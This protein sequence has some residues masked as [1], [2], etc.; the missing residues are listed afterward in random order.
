MIFLLLLFVILIV[1]LV[2]RRKRKV[3]RQSPDTTSDDERDFRQVIRPVWRTGASGRY[4]GNWSK[5]IH[6]NRHVPDIDTDGS[7][8]SDSGNTINGT[9]STKTMS[10]I[11]ESS[12][13]YQTERDL[14]HMSVSLRPGTSLQETHFSE[15]RDV[16][17]VQ[18]RPSVSYMDQFRP[19]V[20][21]RKP[22]STRSDIIGPNYS[23]DFSSGYLSSRPASAL[24]LY[25]HP[26]SLPQ[27][28][29]TPTC[30]GS[31]TSVF[32][33]QHDCFAE[34]LSGDTI[35]EM[36]EEEDIESI[37]KLVSDGIDVGTDGFTDR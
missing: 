36:S 17:T 13:S 4:D 34:E 8:H 9:R 15:D 2:Q 19:D 33:C 32:H 1:I 16:T 6:D 21:Y 24:D 7:L 11:S 20:Y 12:Q 25:L 37:K 3:S 27:R 14:E 28:V 18:H 10:M 29:T 30:A 35:E 23:R 31:R 22:S 26:S 5:Y